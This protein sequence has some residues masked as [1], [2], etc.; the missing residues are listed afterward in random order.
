MRSARKFL[1]TYNDNYNKNIDVILEEDLFLTQVVNVL[2]MVVMAA[3]IA[4]AFGINDTHLVPSYMTVMVALLV[5]FLACTWLK[6]NTDKPHSGILIKACMYLVQF[7]LFSFC[8]S[9]I[10]FGGN[11]TPISYIAFLILLPVLFVDRLY[12]KVIY[13]IIAIA[14]FVVLQLVTFAPSTSRDDWVLNAIVVGVVALI[15][16]IYTSDRKISNY[17][18]S[19]RYANASQIDPLTGLMNLRRLSRDVEM[20]RQ[21]DQLQG[22]IMADVDQFKQFNDTFGHAYGD[23]VL[24]SVASTLRNFGIDNNVL[25]YRYGGD[26]FTGLVLESSKLST[27]EA[28]KGVMKAVDNELYFIAEGKPISISISAGFC[29]VGDESFDT[30]LKGADVMMYEV[31][32]KRRGA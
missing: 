3:L 2:M 27:E 4:V 20:Y 9:I 32:R 28:A 11:A 6:K 8:I 21:S 16:A 1:S 19:R 5:V 30:Y 31:K 7:L 14:T 26:E 10:F 13:Q 23:S 12:I 18:A 24:K 22:V 25:F 29:E 15:C 17:E